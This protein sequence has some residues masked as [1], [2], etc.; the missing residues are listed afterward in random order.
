MHNVGGTLNKHEYGALAEL[1]WQTKIEVQVE[2]L[3]TAILYIK[4]TITNELGLNVDSGGD[5][6]TTKP[7][8][9]WQ[10]HTYT[11]THTHTSS[12]HNA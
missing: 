9:P 4:N 10:N 12:V 7:P 2:S 3:L 6:P 1:Y 8:E 11:H 5:R